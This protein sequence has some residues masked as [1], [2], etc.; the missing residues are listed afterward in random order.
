MQAKNSRKVKR[1]V[2]DLGRR[3]HERD[4]VICKLFRNPPGIN[5]F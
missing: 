5:E 4:I 1:H 2:K 3:E